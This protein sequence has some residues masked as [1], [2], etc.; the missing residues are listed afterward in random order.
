M[1][2]FSTL[3]VVLVLSV[4]AQPAH[5]FWPNGGT[6]VFKSWGSDP[7]ICS[8][9]KGGAIMAWRDARATDANVYAQRVNAARDTLLKSDSPNP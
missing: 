7:S 6:L 5:A 2:W 4:M 9:G 1:K 3:L 8:D